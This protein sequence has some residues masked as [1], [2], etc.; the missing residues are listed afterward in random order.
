MK[1]ALFEIYFVEDIFEIYFVEDIFGMPSLRFMNRAR[2]YVSSV[3]GFKEWLWVNQGLLRA[4]IPFPDLPRI[5]LV[6]K[7]QSLFRRRL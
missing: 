5:N 6:C 7:C 4:L 2:A 3:M 1:N